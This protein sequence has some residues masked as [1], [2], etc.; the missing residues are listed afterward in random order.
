MKPS[1]RH[2]VRTNIIV[3]AW[4]M[5]R[6]PLRKAMKITNSV[7]DKALRAIHSPVFVLPTVQTAIQDHIEQQST[8]NGTQ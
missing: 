6:H 8:D 2:N 7:K 4:G 3:K 5:M 1:E